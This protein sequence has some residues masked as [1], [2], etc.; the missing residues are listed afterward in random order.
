MR[1]LAVLVL[2]PPWLGGFA[3]IKA[4]PSRR[5]PRST[6]VLVL[7]VGP[8]SCATPLAGLTFRTEMGI[9]RCFLLKPMIILRV[10]WFVGSLCYLRRSLKDRTTHGSGTSETPLASFFSE[11]AVL[12]EEN[13]LIG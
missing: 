6:P 4:P 2:L 13:K 10:L 3:Q 9:A 11:F 12:K 8:A 1:F 7:K 5:I